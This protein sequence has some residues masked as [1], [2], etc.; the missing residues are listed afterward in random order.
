MK[1]FNIKASRSRLST[2]AVLVTVFTLLQNY[3]YVK[4]GALGFCVVFSIG[5]AVL[6]V[7]APGK[8]ASHDEA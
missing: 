6:I 3:A 2:V 7:T 1:Q 5:S 4:A 8:H